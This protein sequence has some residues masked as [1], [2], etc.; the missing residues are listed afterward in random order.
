MSYWV[1]LRMSRSWSPWKRPVME[2]S[3]SFQTDG[4]AWDT[5]S[6]RCVG[7]K[8][9]S[10]SGKMLTHSP[11]A[12]GEVIDG[13]KSLE[14][15]TARTISRCWRRRGFGLLSMFLR[16]SSCRSQ[17]PVLRDCG[18]YGKRQQRKQPRKEGTLLPGCHRSA[19]ST[20]GIHSCCACVKNQTAFTGMG[21]VAI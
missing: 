12:H 20:L 9:F 2:W 4:T 8:E 7:T 15:G 21:I 18:T 5:S 17:R 3:A 13:S 11:A 19:I 10:A 1:S 16:W 14:S 6:W